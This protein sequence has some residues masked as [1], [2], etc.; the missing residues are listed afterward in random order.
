[1]LNDGASSENVFVCLSKLRKS[2]HCSKMHKAK[3]AEAAA[4]R[5]AIDRRMENFCTDKGHMIRSILDKPFHKVVLNHLVVDDELV[6]DSGEVKFKYTLLQYVDNDAFSGVMDVIGFDELFQVIKYLPDGKAAG[7]SGIPNELWKHCDEIILKGL[8]NLLNLC[9]KRQ[10]S[11]CGYQIDTKFVAKLGRIS[12]ISGTTSFFTTGVFVNDTIWIRSSQTVTQFIL[13]VA[14]KA[15]SDVKFFSNMVLCKT[16]SDKQ[17]LYLVSAVLQ[18]I[19]GYCT[20]FSFV[21]SSICQYWDAIIRKSF[22]SKAGLFWNFPNK[23]LYYPL[24]YGLKT[25]EQIQAEVKSASVINFSNASGVVGQL[26]EH[27]FLNLQVLGWASLNPLQYLVRLQV[28]LF[29]NFLAGIVHIFLNNNIS[30]VNNLPSA[31]L[32]SGRYLVSGVLGFSLYYDQIVSLKRFGMAFCDKLLDKHGR[33]LDW[34]IF[35]YWKRL[36]LWRPVSSWFVLVLRFL[37]DVIPS[38]ASSDES[39]KG[40]GSTDVAGGAVVYF[41]EIRLGIGVKIVGLLFLTMAE[42]QTVVLVLKCVPSFCSSKVKNHSGIVSNDCA[43]VLMDISAHFFL[44][45]PT[46]KIGLSSKILCGFL[47]HNID[48]IKTVAVW[49]LDLDMLSGL[50]S[51]T[52]ASLHS[53]FMKTVYGRLPIVVKK[54]LYNKK[55]LGILCLH[56]DEVEFSDHV[57]TCSKEAVSHSEILFKWVAVW[58]FLAGFHLLASSV[59]LESLLSYVY[60]VGLYVLF[61]KGFVLLGWF[62]EAVWI[63]ENC[64]E[65]V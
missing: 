57:F 19:I 14:T 30:L 21:S 45:L 31:F 8:L 3:A 58:R 5:H 40:L 41:P 54:R 43:D 48:W 37:H 13:N 63:F 16:I 36:D 35:W 17:F 49:H 61:C 11:L 38:S 6:L 52:L 18:L 12:N 33:V 56:C 9:L 32:N 44:L 64:K 22:K 46:N 10:K 53:Y 62:E 28:S 2:Y 42:L 34:Q 4:I 26:F 29:N 20:Q 24:L 60:D 15:Q 25:F 23:M 47:V 7:L 1:M 50:T 65:T 51:K 55:Y 27:W 59:I 39:L